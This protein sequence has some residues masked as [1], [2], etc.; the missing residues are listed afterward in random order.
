VF[1]KGS[2]KATFTHDFKFD[3][4]EIV[5]QEFIEYIPRPVDDPTTSPVPEGKPEGKKKGISKK[6]VAAL[7]KALP[8]I[9]ESAINDFGIAPSTLR[10]LEVTHEFSLTVSPCRRG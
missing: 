2:L 6:A 1:A 5:S 8:V 7:R 9:S 10:L 4:L 3:L